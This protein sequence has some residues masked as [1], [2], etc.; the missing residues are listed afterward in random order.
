MLGWKAHTVGRMNK[1]GKGTE[2]VP[3]ASCHLQEMVKAIDRIT[4]EQICHLK[5]RNYLITAVC[6]HSFGTVSQK[7][8]FRGG[9]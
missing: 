7:E 8:E 1:I 4:P 6:G 2:D 3:R 5:A 9:G